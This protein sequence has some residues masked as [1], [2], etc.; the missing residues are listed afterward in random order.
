MSAL[1]QCAISLAH[2]PNVRMIP[3]P[4]GNQYW[5]CTPLPVQIGRATQKVKLVWRMISTCKLDATADAPGDLCF[6]RHFK[7]CAPHSLKQPSQLACPM[8]M[9]DGLWGLL[10]EAPKP[11]AASQLQIMQQLD[12][13]RPCPVWVR[14]ARVVPNWN[15]CV[16]IYLFTPA[17]AIQI[18]G[19]Q[20]FAS[21]HHGTSVA[22]QQQADVRCN[23]AAWEGGVPLLRMHH[24]D[25]G[26]HGSDLL[27]RVVAYVQDNP[28]HK[29]LVLSYSFQSV[30]FEG[31]PPVSPKPPYTKHVQHEL[32]C[33]FLINGI[34]GSTWFIKPTS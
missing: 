18:D 21:P 15:A 19:H 8:C 22:A 29:L 1:Q 14:E 5:W 24:T 30:R 20:H 10:R 16:D 9:D 11:C 6:C 31:L 25:C 12:A 32:D 27:I 23:K 2:N 3:S 28:K 33:T 13:M 17:L 26:Q 34:H 4:G 7:W